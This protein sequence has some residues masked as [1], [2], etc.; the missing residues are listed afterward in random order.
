MLI[1]ITLSLNDVWILLGENWCWSLLGLQ[2]L[3]TENKGPNGEGT[4]VVNIRCVIFFTWAV[5]SCLEKIS[6]F[7]FGS[8]KNALVKPW[9]FYNNFCNRYR[10]FNYDQNLNGQCYFL[11]FNNN[12]VNNFIDFYLRHEDFSTKTITNEKSKIKVK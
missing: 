10:D 2:G 9:F 4:Q 12:N 3:T 1:L 7:Y 8:T 6:H 11:I 5:D